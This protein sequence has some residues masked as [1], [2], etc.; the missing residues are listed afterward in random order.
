MLK[1]ENIFYVIII[2]SSYAGL[3]AA[4][5]LDRALRLRNVLIMDS[6]NLFNIQ[7]PYA[8]NF[9]TQG[10]ET[11]KATTDKVK[12]QVLKYKTIKFYNGLAIIGLKKENGFE[13]KTKSSELFTAKKLI[14]A[15]G[16]KDIM[17]DIKVFSA[18]WGISII[19]CRYCH[20][21][22]Y[23]HK[24]TG[25]PDSGDMAFELSRLIGN[26]AKN[27]TLFTNGASTLSLKKGK[28]L[29]ENI[30]LRCISMWRQ[31]NLTTLRI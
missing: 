19:H 3:S 22:E 5:A 26:W 21:Y 24:K 23:S 9:V 14:F 1:S 12:V 18:C 31:C 2:G 6:E 25:I 15:T 8:H 17:P 4:M 16:V 28:K 7:T 11:P 20:D 29:V 27:L 13:I 30:Y 10:G